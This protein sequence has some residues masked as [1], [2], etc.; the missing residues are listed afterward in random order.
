MKMMQTQMG[1]GSTSGTYRRVSSLQ[2]DH[3]GDANSMIVPCFSWGLNDLNVNILQKCKVVHLC[4][5]IYM[6]VCDYM[7]VEIYGYMNINMRVCYLCAIVFAR[8]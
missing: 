2:R 1:A 3:F 6:C 8:F 4:I 5:Y 7:R